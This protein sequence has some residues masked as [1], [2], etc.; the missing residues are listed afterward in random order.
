MTK[1]KEIIN[2]E[3]KSMGR[4][5]SLVSKKALKGEEIIVV[6]CSKAIIT[7]D[8]YRIIEEYIKKRKRGGSSQRGPYFPSSPER[9]LKRTIRGMLPYKKQRGKEALK[10]VKCYNLVPEGVKVEEVKFK[11][12]RLGIELKDLSKRIKGK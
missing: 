11:K 2:A 3:G 7:G 12:A 1:D 5:A 10:R 9:I 8:K 4:I 6:N